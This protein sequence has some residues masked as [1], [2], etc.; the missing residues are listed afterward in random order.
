VCFRFGA[1][2]HRV[3]TPWR[4]M[5]VRCE[6]RGGE[7]ITWG[8]QAR[9]IRSHLGHSFLIV[10]AKH[11]QNSLNAALI[12]C[13]IINRCLTIP[14]KLILAPTSHSNVTITLAICSKIQQWQ[15]LHAR[16][17][18]ALSKTCGIRTARPVDLDD[19]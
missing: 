5:T 2:Q 16:V 10:P 17:P 1:T 12:V 8:V 4:S 9:Y 14:P 3:L 19:V 18:V 7:A 13:A 11:I 6:G 15:P